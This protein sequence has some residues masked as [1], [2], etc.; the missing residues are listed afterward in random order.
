MRFGAELPG[1][2]PLTYLADQAFV[3]CLERFL[4]AIQLHLQTIETRRPPV[5]PH[6]V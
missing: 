4:V 3:K 2:E 6:M 5:L 1:G